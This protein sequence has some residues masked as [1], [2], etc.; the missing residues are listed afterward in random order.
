MRPSL[1][2]F[3]EAMDKYGGNV[4]AVAKA[5]KVR[6]NTVYTWMQDEEYKNVLDDAR[7]NFLDDAIAS[8]RI[9]VRGI[10]D[11][12]KDEEGKPKQVGWLSPP[13]SGMVRYI[14]GTLGRNEGFG[15]RLDIT[16]NGKDINGLF[17]VLTKDE[18]KEAAEQFDKDY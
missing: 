10:P 17:R 5:F 18:M 4:S 9:L 2:K 6:R 8:A 14:L 15:E 13:D 16:T 3:T 1:E 11:V 7:G 12:I